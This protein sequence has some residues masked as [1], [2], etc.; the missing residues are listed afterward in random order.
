MFTKKNPTELNNNCGK[1]VDSPK[2]SSLYAKNNQVACDDIHS[3][4]AIIPLDLFNDNRE[5]FLK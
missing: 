5:E 2:N 1:K 3:K 4:R